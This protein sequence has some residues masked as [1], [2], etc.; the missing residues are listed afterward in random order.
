MT[1]LTLRLSR[2]SVAHLADGCLRIGTPM[3]VVAGIGPIVPGQRAQ[4]RAI[5]VRHYGSVDVFLEALS[6]AQADDVLVVDN[7]DREDEGC[8]GD[9]AALELAGAGLSGIIIW[10]RHRDTAIVRTLPIAL[11][12]RGA[13]ARGPVRLDPREPEAFVS[14]RIADELV[15]AA[16]WVVADDDGAIFID[17][18]LVASVTDAAEAIR[19]VEVRQARQMSEGTSLREQLRFGDYL[20]ARAR[21]PSVDFRTFL[22]SRNAAIEE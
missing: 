13:C 8:I 16:D 10:G 5:P 2:L 11:F 9:L 6:N 3:R 20:D 18:S 21:D 15:T 12:S 1:D 17:D 19:D 14:A 4:G 22:R 7:G